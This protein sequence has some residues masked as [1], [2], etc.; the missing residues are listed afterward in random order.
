[1]G[2]NESL[3]EKVKNIT[4]L[5]TIP[6]I[7]A[8]ILSLSEEDISSS[9]PLVSIIEKDPAISAKVL[10][11]ASAAF[12]GFVSPPRSL[13][14]AVMRLGFQHVKNIALGIA[15]LS[16]FEKETKKGGLDY[17]RIF[18]HSVATGLVSKLIS[19]RLNL[20]ISGEAL[21]SGILHDIGLLVLS[22]YFHDL[23]DDVLATRDKER[24]LYDVERD[25]LGFTHSDIGGWLA[26]QWKL[27]DNVQDAIVYHHL[28]SVAVN[29]PEHVAVVNIANYL[30]SENIL[31]N[32]EIE[33]KAFYDPSALRILNI[34]EDDLQRFASELK[35]GSMF[36]G[37][38]I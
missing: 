24:T 11:L 25:V 12:F 34:K 37:L 18:N 17:V 36:S 28:P 16:V 21:M 32:T 35:D 38:F 27:P 15:L 22:R 29:N 13:E 7:A 19:D 6:A 10:S 14:T 26:D 2:L 20:L 4:K 1:M 8:E 3:M 33:F 5:P 30:V 9:K 31:R 23:Y